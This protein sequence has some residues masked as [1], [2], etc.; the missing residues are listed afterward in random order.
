MDLITEDEDILQHP[1]PFENWPEG[2][3]LQTVNLFNN[4]EQMQPLYRDLSVLPGLSLMLAP[5]VILGSNWAE[6]N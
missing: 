2:H 4:W 3:F 5:S 1:Q 6:K